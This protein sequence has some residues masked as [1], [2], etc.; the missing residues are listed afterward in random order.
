[1][2]IA[3]GIFRQIRKEAT[4][5]EGYF[6]GGW[7]ISDQV[8]SEVA[9]WRVAAVH[10]FTLFQEVSRRFIM[11]IDSKRG[12]NRTASFGE[13]TQV[14]L[15]QTHSLPGTKMVRVKRQNGC[16]VRDCEIVLAEQPDE[17]RAP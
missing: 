14:K 17:R 13:F 15:T 4:K 12:A 1:M 9:F 11:G 10:L 8:A 5:L 2:T 3:R 6:R 7:P 16:A